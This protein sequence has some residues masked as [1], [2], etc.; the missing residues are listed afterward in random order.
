MFTTNFKA[1]DLWYT[2]YF[3][4]GL[5]ILII[6][7][8]WNT[9]IHKNPR[10]NTIISLLGALT[11]FFTSF[12]IIIQ[13]Y[14]FHAQQTDSE[15]QLYDS[16]F[17]KLYE[18]SIG[19]FQNNP[20]MTYYYNEIFKPINYKYSPPSQRYYTE[21]HQITQL[22]L[23]DLAAL[24]YFIQNDKSIST[25]NLSIIQLKFDKF[26]TDLI[27]SPTFMENYYHLKPN[28][29]SIQLKDYLESNYNI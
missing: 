11:I 23:R 1:A 22:T 28:L 29:F 27:S 2:V 5:T 14:T 25:D 20:K 15:I 4:F 6:I 8:V 19:Y 24:L 9:S 17:N 7:V 18:D 26:I 12:A 16:M 10:F 3:L 13:L 21:E